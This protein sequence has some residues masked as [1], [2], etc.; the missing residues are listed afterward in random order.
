MIN[1]LHKYIA[2]KFFLTFLSTFLALGALTLLVD[3][4]EMLR[5]SSDLPDVTFITISLISLTKLPFLMEQI[6]P[7]CIIIACIS[8][9]WSLTKS[10]E[11]II[12]RAVGMSA[13]S[14]IS[15]IVVITFIIG[16]FATLIFNP[17]S[18]SMYNKHN[19]L[20]EKNGFSSDDTSFLSED[21]LWL[22][23]TQK[24]LS[25]IIHA[26]K[27]NLIH[28]NLELND[29]SIINIKNNHILTSRIESKRGIIKDN[30]ILIPDATIFIPE[31]LPKKVKN[32]QVKTSIT[33][34]Q[35]QENMTSPEKISFWDM[36]KIISFFENSGLSSKPFKLYYYSLIALPF[37]LSAFVLTVTPFMMITNP[38]KSNI[39]VRIVF[40]VIC[41]FFLFFFAKISIALAA[42]STIPI[43]MA[44]II[45]IIITSFCGFAA[46][47]HSEDG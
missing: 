1:L 2:K 16:L 13:K 42:S 28:D 27:I 9:L 37:L 31:T 36:P 47:L 20:L 44:I 23:E 7:F 6:L 24:D 18:A 34:N 4:I 39:F 43:S 21:G 3:I 38:R 32:H 10:S 12:Y 29:I 33:V 15:P 35:L 26:K 22:R 41:G 30:I 40:A 25:V 5:K 17:F 8:S 45:P 11:L 14:F 19:Q 46:I